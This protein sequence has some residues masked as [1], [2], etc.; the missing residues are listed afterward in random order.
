MEEK[1]RNEINKAAE[2]L[3]MEVS[4]VQAKYM[5]ICDANSLDPVDDMLLARSLFR[6][7]FSGAYQYKDAPQQETMRSE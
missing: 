6:Q 2:M 1:I 7:W 4:E 3:Q 5:E